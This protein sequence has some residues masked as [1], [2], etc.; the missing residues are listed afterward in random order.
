MDRG[1]RIRHHNQAA[2]GLTPDRGYSSLDFRGVA[3]ARRN[4]FDFERSGD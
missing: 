1:E 4:R 2:A 3:D